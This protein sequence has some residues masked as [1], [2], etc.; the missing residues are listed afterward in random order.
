MSYKE[1]KAMEREELRRELVARA[2]ARRT[3]LT[4]RI[5]HGIMLVFLGLAVIAAARSFFV[6]DHLN[7]DPKIAAGMLL[8]AAWWGKGLLGKKPGRLADLGLYLG[9]ALFL[10]AL[11]GCTTTS[12]ST[13]TPRIDGSS[14]AA[15]QASYQTLVATLNSEQQAK[16]NTAIFLIGATKFRD[17]QI[18][19]FGPETLRKDLDGKTYDDIIKAGVATG[20]RIGGIEHHG[21]ATQ[22]SLVAH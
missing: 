15:F 12:V 10:L 17:T 16:L 6:K 13:A 5:E 1:L 20:A 18:K 2:E 11:V 21:S 22:P 7:I 19:E 3:S 14:A 4:G 8:G 9:L